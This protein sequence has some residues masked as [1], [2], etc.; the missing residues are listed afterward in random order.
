MAG[1]IWPRE[2]SLL[3]PHPDSRFYRQETIV[4][5][6]CFIYSKGKWSDLKE[7]RDLVWFMFLKNYFGSCVVILMV[8]STSLKN[9]SVGSWT[10]SSWLR[11]LEQTI[12]LAK[13]LQICWFLSVWITEG[14]SFSFNVDSQSIVIKISPFSSIAKHGLGNAMLEDAFPAVHARSF[15]LFPFTTEIIWPVTNWS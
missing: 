11:S 8:S 3:T 1:Q 9:V 7:R 13:A 10:L 2:W 6:G 5:V 4:G 14:F 15:L 12:F